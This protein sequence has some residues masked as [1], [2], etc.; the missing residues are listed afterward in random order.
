M[1]ASSLHSQNGEE[2]FELLRQ[3]RGVARF[4]REGVSPAFRP[5]IGFPAAS[6]SLA[7]KPI[8]VIPADSCSARPLDVSSSQRTVA[9]GVSAYWSSCRREIVM[10]CLLPMVGPLFLALLAHADAR[11]QDPSA[12]PPEMKPL[13]RML[14]NW[15]IEQETKVP[16]ERRSTNTVKGVWS[17][18]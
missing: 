14:G 18:Y 9:Y 5:R 6:S 12:P 16:A 3:A 2:P 13:E 17:K 10:K 1:P 8:A 11:G 7:Q 15:R 4:S